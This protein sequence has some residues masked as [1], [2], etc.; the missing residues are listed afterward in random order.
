MSK[1]KSTLTVR[2]KEGANTD[3]VRYGKV[4]IGKTD[5]V[6][7]DDGI[8]NHRAYSLLENSPK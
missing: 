7:V 3:F 6:E 5:F 1:S 4:L 2:V 8:K